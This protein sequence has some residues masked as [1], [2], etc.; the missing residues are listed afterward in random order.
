MKTLFCLVGRSGCGKDTIAKEL[1]KRY[2]LNVISSFTTRDI[3]EGERNG[4]EHIFISKAKFLKMF[5]SRKLSAWTYFNKHF[6]GTTKQAVRNN[7]I[8]VVDVKGVESLI[9][10]MKKKVKIVPIQ[11][12]VDSDTL[13]ER[14]RHRGDSD[15]KINSR[16][17]NDNKMFK[18]IDDICPHRVLNYNLEDAVD[19]VWRIIK[20]E[21]GICWGD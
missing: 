7:D 21:K 14:M 3:R 4:V 8:Y 2:D 16:L 5:F 1:E 11:I 12:M 15:D 17:K 10:T 9:K 20:R 6:Y 19:D 18:K 13:V